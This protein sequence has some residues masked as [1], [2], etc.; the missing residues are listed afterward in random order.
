MIH[1][2]MQYRHAH[3]RS[4]AII[5]APAAPRRV[6]PATISHHTRTIIPCTAARHGTSPV[7]LYGYRGRFWQGTCTDRWR[8]PCTSPAAL[9]V[10]LSCT[11]PAALRV[12]LARP[13]SLYTPCTHAPKARPT[14]G[15]PPPEPVLELARAPPRPP[16]HRATRRRRLRVGGPRAGPRRKHKVRV[17]LRRR[18][19]LGRV[20]AAARRARLLQRRGPV[21]AA[22]RAPVLHSTVSGHTSE[23]RHRTEAR[24]RSPP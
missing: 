11:S 8:A 9:R 12:R 1:Y 5:H 17:L 3:T 2:I 4:L 7:A 6:P 13:L 23:A 14:R 19:P 15:P 20:R 10:H 22:P 16:H 24:D 21:P 18:G